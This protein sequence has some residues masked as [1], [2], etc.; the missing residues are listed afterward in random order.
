[1]KSTAKAQIQDRLKEGGSPLSSPGAF[2]GNA[3]YGL[4][5]L[6][7]SDEPCKTTPQ[8][9]NTGYAQLSAAASLNRISVEA[10]A[11]L[12]RIDYNLHLL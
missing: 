5:T 12:I 3:P 9:G 11:E 10:L 6:W 2:F 8:E 7:A 1:M 4:Q